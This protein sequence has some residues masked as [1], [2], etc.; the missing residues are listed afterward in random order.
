M[1]SRSYYIMDQVL[2]VFTLAARICILP[3]AGSCGKQ[4]VHLLPVCVFVPVR[5]SVGVC[6][7]EDGKAT[8]NE[9]LVF[10]ADT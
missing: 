5:V 6:V 7:G 9:S 1:L 4:E 3:P 10:P 2:K 8:A